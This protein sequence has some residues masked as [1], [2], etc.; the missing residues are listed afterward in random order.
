LPFPLSFAGTPA[1]SVQK[2][3][4]DQHW[5]NTNSPLILYNAEYKSGGVQKL[6]GAV[7]CTCISIFS[8]ENWYYA[9]SPLKQM[10]CFFSCCPSTVI[11]VMNKLESESFQYKKPAT[12]NCQ[13]IFS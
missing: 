5:H 6:S 2:R 11:G 4:T 3:W 8:K 13:T 1:L 10:I 12:F 9:D 7:F